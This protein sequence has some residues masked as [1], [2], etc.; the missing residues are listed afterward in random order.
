MI[1]TAFIVAIGGVAASAFGQANAVAYNLTAI[2]MTD[3][4]RGTAN[5]AVGDVFRIEVSAVHNGMSLGL[6]KFDIAVEGS[7]P[8]AATVVEDATAAFDLVAP[9]RGRHPHMRQATSDKPNGAV[10][11]SVITGH[12][13]DGDSW[14]MSDAAQGG[15]D[16]ATF[17]PTFN[18]LIG[19]F[20]IGTGEAF[21]AFDY[22]YDGGVDTLNMVVRGAARLYR[23]S[24]DGSGA[25]VSAPTV[26]NGV[27]ITPAPGSL[28]LLGA[29][30]LLAARRRRA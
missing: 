30:G 9:V 8:A 25:T 27:T 29:G 14:V 15:I 13:V 24:T 12:A 26:G 11:A 5:A 4:L 2:N 16:L 10:G 6:A 3:A 1:K 17:P 23:S 19:L 7:T 28:A 21:F 20:P 18:P 22:V